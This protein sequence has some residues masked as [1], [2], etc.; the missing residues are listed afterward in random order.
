MQMIHDDL[1]GTTFSNPDQHGEYA[2][3]KMAALT[4]TLTHAGRGH[5]SQLRAQRLALAASQIRG[6]LLS[7][8]ILSSR[9]C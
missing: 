3:E 5:L 8:A 6:Q 9:L 1:P 2:S 7:I 4:G